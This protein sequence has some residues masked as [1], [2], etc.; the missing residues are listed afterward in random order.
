MD[1]EHEEN[2]EDLRQELEALGTGGTLSDKEAEERFIAWYEDIC[3]ERMAMLEAEENYKNKINELETAEEGYKSRVKELENST[4]ILVETFEEAQAEIKCLRE[5]YEPST[6]NNLYLEPYQTV[7]RERDNL[8]KSESENKKRIQGLETEV[9]H[10]RNYVK[11]L[12]NAGM[13]NKKVG[14]TKDVGQ[15]FV[16]TSTERLN[17]LERENENLKNK[18]ERMKQ[19]NKTMDLKAKLTNTKEKTTETKSLFKDNS[20]KTP[21]E[22]LV[23]NKKSIPAFLPRIENNNSSLVS[24]PKR[25]KRVPFLQRSCHTPSLMFG[26]GYSDIYRKV[27]LRSRSDDSTSLSSGQFDSF[28]KYM[29]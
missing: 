15:I 4:N 27:L 11:G 14:K 6:G 22:K 20:F 17:T 29:I 24:D 13:E 2:E 19:K 5:K 7:T 10:L 21:K 26:L 3:Q 1:E 12:N 25:S 9:K 18:L 8:L 28:S 23:M 16:V